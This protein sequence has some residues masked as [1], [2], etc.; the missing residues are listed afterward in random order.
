MNFISLFS[1][2]GG[3]DL[4]FQRAGMEC[5]AVCEIDKA[6]QG[7][8]RRANRREKTLP[9]QLEQA[10]QQVAQSQPFKQEDIKA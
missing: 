2:I 1:G 10:L 8:L 5:V 6:A 3:F 4:A 9:P 7:I